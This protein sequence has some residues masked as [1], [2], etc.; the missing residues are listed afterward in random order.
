MKH[1]IANFIANMLLIPV[2]FS[3][4][5][6]LSAWSLSFTDRFTSDRFWNSICNYQ[7]DS[8]RADTFV[9]PFLSCRPISYT[10]TT[11]NQLKKMSD[12]S[13]INEDIYG[14]TRL[15]SQNKIYLNLQSSS[16]AATIVSFFNLSS[17]KNSSNI[18]K[19]NQNEFYLFE[20]GSI[21]YDT[22]TQSGFAWIPYFLADELISNHLASSYEGL[23]GKELQM[24]SVRKNGTS[25]NIPHRIGNIILDS[26][27]CRRLKQ[28]FGTYFVVNFDLVYPW[29]NNTYDLSFDLDF[30]NNTASN[31]ESFSYFRSSVDLSNFDFDV[32]VFDHPNSKYSIS[33]G[34]T[35][36]FYKTLS[37]DTNKNISMYVI[38]VLYLVCYFFLARF[39]CKKI[40]K[41]TFMVSFVV[42]C[43]IELA[44]GFYFIYGYWFYLWSLPLFL[45]LSSNIV[46]FFT[47]DFK[48]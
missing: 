22:S 36:L 16:E 3:A 10:D 23:I 9:M 5:F 27:G 47:E 35:S 6:S 11:I 41:K 1:K 40:D 39:V 12:Y 24:Q 14:G 38:A 31:M 25:V 45:F 18:L 33:E 46:L 13:A 44:L 8:S 26:I 20:Q 21:D 2:L 29:S 34:D 30:V 43:F 4:L 19:T 48:Q 7:T 17:Y 37:T 15:V 28:L 32:S 42:C